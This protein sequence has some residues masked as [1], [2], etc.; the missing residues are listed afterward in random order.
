MWKCNAAVQLLEEQGRTRKWL[1]KQCEI[2]VE[3]L[4]HLLAGRRSPS[5]PVL[6]LLAQALNT[7]VDHL[8]DAVDE[9]EG[10]QS[11]TG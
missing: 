3:S 10:S 4:N 8:L 1:A 2:E 11:A 6:K 5:R 7:S 9:G